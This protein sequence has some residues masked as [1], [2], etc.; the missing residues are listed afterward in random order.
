MKPIETGNL[1]SRILEAPEKRGWFLGHFIDSPSLFHSKDVEVKWGIHKK[2]EKYENAKANI[3][4]KSLAILISGKEKFFF[5]DTNETITMEKP[6]DYIIWNAGIFHK[7][8]MLEDTTILTICW[9]SSPNDTV[10]K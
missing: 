3:Q 7:C 9:P 4:A 8:E 2:G 10:S 5:P 6:G 1:T